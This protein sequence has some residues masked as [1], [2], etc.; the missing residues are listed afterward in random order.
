MLAKAAGTPIS[1]QIAITASEI[2]TDTRIE[3]RSCWFAKTA[4]YQRVEKPDGGN[5]M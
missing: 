3:S 5:A 2:R 4:W 1:R